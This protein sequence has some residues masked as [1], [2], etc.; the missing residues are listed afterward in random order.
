MSEF[1]MMTP[2]QGCRIV[3]NKSHT[4]LVGQPP[5]VLKGVMRLGI[6]EFDTL[7]LLDTREKNG[8]LLNNLEFPLY[9]FLF[10]SSG[11]AQNKRL[12][13]VG[14][15]LLLEQMMELLRLTLFG[16]SAAELENWATEQGLKEEWLTMCYELALKDSEQ[17]MLNL[18]DFFNLIA[19]DDKQAQLDELVI[20]HTGHDQYLIQ[21]GDDEVHVDLTEDEMIAPPYD[22]PMDYVSS[23]LVKFGLEVLGGASGFS[24]DEP[25]TGI[26]LC[27]NG[28]Y[29]LI[30]SI[31]FLD[32]H[33]YARGISKNQISAVFL[34][35]LHDDHCSMFPLMLMPHRV[36]IITTKEIF[37]MAMRKLACQ[38][39][40]PDSVV[41]QSFNFIPIEP[42]KTLN[43]FG[44]SITAHVTVHS[45]P[46]IGAVFSLTHRGVE[47]TICVVG[48]NHSMQVI[49]D[50]VGRK[51]V[52]ESTFQR[53]Q[54]LFVE[55]YD[56]LVADGGGGAIHGDPIDALDSQ[57]DRI[58]FVHVDAL[59]EELT[60]TFS[61]ASSGKRYTLFDGDIG[62]YTSQITH[63]LSL[64]LGQEFPSRWMRSLLAEQE[65]LHFNRDDV[66]IVQGAPTKG[67]V[68]LMLTGYCDVIYQNNEKRTLVAQLQAGDIIGEMAMI[69]GGGVRN[70]SVVART[71]ITV[72]ALREETFGQFIQHSGLGDDLVQRWKIRPYVSQ[73]AQYK[74][75]N[76]TV[77]EKITKVCSLI[78]LKAGES[79]CLNDD[80][81]VILVS[82]KASYK[83][84]D[85]QAYEADLN[86]EFGYSTYRDSLVCEFNAQENCLLLQI[87]ACKL[88]HLIESTPQLSYQLRRQLN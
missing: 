2:V 27:H 46:T 3:S 28:D 50:M 10:F 19:F 60:A 13:L 31:P 58:V 36:D 57:A 20:F 59:P 71:P 88:D 30:D 70:A 26:A 47:K 23:G 22:V 80:A 73:I 24:Q 41:E 64:W 76:S 4:L 87:A 67:W 48:D 77:I 11:L 75:L 40:W 14:D 8:S 52:R 37:Y 32:Q 55:P 17:N 21:S 51:Q 33:L 45:I 63:Y 1:Q 74:E 82:G 29:L 81:Q 18:D 54:Q 42:N 79:I 5:E 25:C 34:T 78:E 62:I 16:P 84:A 9:F 15:A 83:T 53:L 35:H 68:Y 65:I 85:S 69:S 39:G 56:L 12:N 43:Y 38:L 44:L 66:V 61:L 72:C 7:V 6:K 49:K 86:Q